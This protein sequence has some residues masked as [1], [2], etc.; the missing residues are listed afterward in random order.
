MSA[1]NSTLRR[2]YDDATC[3]ELVRA[4][5]SAYLPPDHSFGNRVH[6]CVERG[7][8]KT[9]F[10]REFLKGDRSAAKA[11][12]VEITPGD[13]AFFVLGIVG[14]S[15]QMAAFKL[16]DRVAGLRDVA[17]A[18]LVKRVRKLLKRYGHAEFT[19]DAANYRPAAIPAPA[20]P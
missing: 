12:G 9:F 17:D 18:I 11:M 7:F 6:N 13:E 20:A 10:L 4:T 8:A 1:R 16:A 2:G 19:T 15:A 3:G 5:L 14:V